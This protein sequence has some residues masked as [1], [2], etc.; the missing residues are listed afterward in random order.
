[1][2][3]CKCLA[4]IE[5]TRHAQGRAYEYE[6]QFSAKFPVFNEVAFKNNLEIYT[7]NSRISR[8]D[9]CEQPKKTGKRITALA[10]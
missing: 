6:L 3:F 8:D 4:N 2:R 5:L 10:R 7:P 9:I 1:V